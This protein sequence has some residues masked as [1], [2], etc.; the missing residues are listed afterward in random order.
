MSNDGKSVFISDEYGP[1]IYQFDRATGQRIKSFQ[2]PDNLDV[3]NLKPV[4][5]DEIAD[6]TSGRTAN[7]GMEGLALT[8][9]GK[10]LVGTMQAALI[11]DAANSVTK[12]II[13]IVTVDIAS[14][15]THEYAYKL[16]AGSGVSDI[17]ALNDH[18]FLIDERDGAGLGD[19][20]SAAVAKEVYEIDLTGATDVTNLSG[21]ALAAA[22]V[23]KTEFVNLVSLLESDGYADTEIPSKIEGLAFG[24]DVLNDGVLY[25]T[26][27]VGND[28]DFV[29]DEAGPNQFFVL[30]F[31][32]KDLPG[33]EHQAFVPE[34]ATVSLLGG[35]LLA[36]F[37]YRR[38]RL[39]SAD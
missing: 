7:K 17:V 12:K 25:H 6:N 11:Q 4:G 31:T 29:A 20:G 39:F 24:Q 18:Q 30:G 19:N 28:N 23:S 38:K 3:S 21:A 36:M 1:Y 37:G 16:T 32:D 2:L 5:N 26:L 14:G 9:D 8:P 15:T 27:Y 13:R 34:P 10:T 35:A 22:A 33:F